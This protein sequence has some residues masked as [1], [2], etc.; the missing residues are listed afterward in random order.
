M[1]KFLVAVLS[2]ALALSVV[3]PVAASAQSMSMAYAFNT[4]LKVGSRG[5]DV[6]ALQSFLESKGLIVMPAGVAKGYFGTLTRNAVS[7]YQVMKN[8]SPT[9]GFFGP[10]TRQAVMADMAGSPVPPVTG[11]CPAGFTCTPVPGTN[12]GPVVTN[13]IEGTLDVRLASNP[14]DNA[15]VRTQ[16]DVQVYGL[17]IRARIGDVAVQTLDLQVGVTNSGASENPATL[18]NTIKVWDG[19]TL[20]ATVPVSL[21]T[22]TKDQNQVYYYRI[23]G[24]NFMV[25]KDETRNLKVSFNTNSIDSD[26]I[27]TI[28]GYGSSSLRA[29]S[30]NNVSSFYSVAGSGFT[31][32]HTF[33]KP[34]SSTLTLSAAS[35]PLRSQ[36]NR[37]N[38]V[39][40]LNNVSLLTFNLKSETGDSTL[41]TVNASTTASGTLPTTLYLY[42]GSTLLKSKTVSASGTTG[43]VS[44]DNLDTTTGS[45]VPVNTIQ[46]YTVKADFPS[47]TANGTFASTTIASVIFQTPA[48]NSSTASGSAV[49]GVN[50]Y[51]YTKAAVITLAGTPTIIVTP[52]SNSNNGT[53]TMTATFPLNIMA[54]GGNMVVPGTT[55]AE[56]TV[57]FS[58]GTNYTATS[59]SVVTIPNNDIADGSTAAVTVTASVN[60]SVALTNGLYNAALTQIVWNVGGN[61]STTQAYGLD[62]FKTSAAVQFNR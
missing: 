33:K 47:N 29:T 51:V 62:D 31:R 44:F 52:Q 39:D 34:G 18:I 57:V 8:I 24:L 53:T 23:S 19:T 10:I 11:T 60:P 15:S 12:P 14:A 37:V 3:A 26:R 9:A 59:K 45:L 20:L 40:S 4:S 42:Q 16:T 48:G 2:L 55:G 21:T 50:Q 32:T 22:F 1:K 56:F 30:G 41:L 46:T 27:V 17:E 36:N 25:R 61:G 49:A 38:G 54:L 35:S 6:I 7:A 13:G 28:Q 5:A 43:N 58:N